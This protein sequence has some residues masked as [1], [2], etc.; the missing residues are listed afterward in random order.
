MTQNYLE[1]VSRE[2]QTANPL[3]RTL[4]ARLVRAREGEA[5]I[6][7]P[8][9]RH[10][11]Q[12]GGMIAGGVMAALTDEAMAHALMSV[13]EQ[14]ARPVTAEMNIR[15]LR[16]VAPE[17]GGELSALARLVR[18]GRNICVAEAELK[19]SKENLLAVAGATFFLL[20]G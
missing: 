11:A 13:L 1:A 19:D 17:Q 4:N 9:S 18:V 16:G 7:M 3:F 8:V 5:E 20:H 10:V 15:Y 14:G 2:D 12:G 6:R